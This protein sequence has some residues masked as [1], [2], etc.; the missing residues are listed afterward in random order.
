MNVGRRTLLA[1]VVLM[2]LAVAAILI[3][4]NSRANDRTSVR[5]SNNGQVVRLAEGAP[6]EQPKPARRY[7][8]GVLFPFLASP[9]WVN[10]AY[11]VTDQARALGVDLVWYSADGYDNIDKQNSQLEDLVSKHVDA[12]LIA[13]TSS[14]GT[15]PVVDRAAAAGI[16]VFAHVTSSTSSHIISAVLDDDL[17]IG[18]K[19]AAFLGK[20]LGG[21]GQVAMLNGPAAA[22]WSS[23]RARGFKEVIA[24]DFPGIKIVAERFGIPDRA[25]AQRLAEDLFSAFPKLAGLFTVADGMAM[26]AADAARQAGRQPDAMVITTAS[27]SREAVPYMLSGAIDLNV[28]ENPVKIGRVA[29]NTVVHGLNGKSIPKTTYVPN[30]AMTRETVGKVDPKLQW[31]PDTWRLR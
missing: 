5:T 6:V 20:A 17:E 1:V 22:E 27:F 21:K 9:F 2:A 23:L 26:G 3:W 29:I 4:Q 15:A 12:I 19:Q 8:I 25:D 18:R 7:R 11:G 16:P 24:R 10:E 31:A 13:A 28:D 30:P 14:T